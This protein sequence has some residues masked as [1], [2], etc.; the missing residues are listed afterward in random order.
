MLRNCARCGKVHNYPSKYCK[1]C[2][3]T[4]KE[5]FDKVRDYLYDNPNATVEQVHIDTGVERKKIRQYIREDRL[6]ITDRIIEGD[7]DS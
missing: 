7:N 3:E 1:E 5:L 4:E 6:I 2:L